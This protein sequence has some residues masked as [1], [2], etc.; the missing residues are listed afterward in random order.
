MGE[1]QRQS[2]NSYFR[3]QTSRPVDTLNSF[4]LDFKNPVFCV[5]IVERKHNELFNSLH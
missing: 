4:F 3:S 5:R 2:Q 1:G